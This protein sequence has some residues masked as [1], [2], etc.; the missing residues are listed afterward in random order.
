MR[1]LCALQLTKPEKMI[2][3]YDA[4]Y[5]QMWV[6]GKVVHK[7][8]G[9][10]AVFSDLLGEETAKEVVGKVRSPPHCGSRYQE[11]SVPSVLDA[12]AEHIEQ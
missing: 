1:A 11:R 6:Q 9:F 7:P 12:N 8:E 10:T 3:A 4:L 5:N 2:D